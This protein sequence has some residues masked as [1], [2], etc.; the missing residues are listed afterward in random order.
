V[1][2]AAPRC[3]LAPSRASRPRPPP[4]L[5][6]PLQRSATFGGQAAPCGRPTRQGCL[7]ADGRTSFATALRH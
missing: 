5:L 1:P 7:G 6:R 4:T 2:S 3:A